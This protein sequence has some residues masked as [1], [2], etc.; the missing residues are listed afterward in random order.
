MKLTVT[1]KKSRE[2]DSMKEKNDRELEMFK[3]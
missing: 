1:K 3:R 2:R